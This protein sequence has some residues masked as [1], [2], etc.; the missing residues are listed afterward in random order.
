MYVDTS[1]LFAYYIA[2]QKSAT[3][4]RIIGST[5]TTYVSSLTDVEFYSALKKRNRIGQISVEDV[6]L[7]H[8]M[9]KF[10]RSE[11]LFEYIELEDLDFKSAELLLKNTTTPLRTLDAIHLGIAKNHLLA[12]F[13]FDNVLLKAAIELDIQTVNYSG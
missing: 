3:V 6:Q 11:N 10:H 9:Y 7:T 1:T 5:E 4:E 2:E 13:T 12:L 8:E